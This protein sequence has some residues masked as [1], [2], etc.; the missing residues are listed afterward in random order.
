MSQWQGKT[1]MVMAGGT[2]G[3][4]YPAMA[5]AKQVLA[6][7][8]QV[9]WL[10]TRRGLESSIV[11]EAGLPIEYLDIAGLRGN[12]LL[13]WLKA[14][15]RIIKAVGQAISI[16]RRI[17]PDMVLGMG[18]FVTGPGGVA[19]KALSIPLVIHEQNAIP[20]LTNKLLSRIAT[21]VL[22]AFPN[23]IASADECTGNPI[24]QDI[25][26]VDA[27]SQRPSFNPKTPKILVV[28]GSLGA[29]AI[30]QVM[31]EVVKSLVAQGI[32]C[33]VKHQT[34]KHSYEQTVADYQD[35]DITAEVMPFIKDMKSA[36]TWADIVICRSGALT[37]S[38]I[39]SV[40]VASILVP[41]PH[42]VDDHQTENAGYLERINA[43]EIIQQ[44]ALDAAALT[45]KLAELINTNKLPEM[46]EKAW[47]ARRTDATERVLFHCLESSNVK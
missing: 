20:G 29:L 17:K 22:E 25:I 26:D 12:G 7:G 13:G 2:G 5:C 37:V 14:P 30:N 36:Y 18:G 16:Y 4:I 35:K 47:Q 21:R 44:T 27:P 19:A 23:S 6:E 42:A 1:L 3:H 9:C 38:E 33:Q 32:D 43:G 28:G 40:G 24:R 31:P 8:G 45:S 39:M 15:F 41:Y 46:A 34:G 11:P 10:G